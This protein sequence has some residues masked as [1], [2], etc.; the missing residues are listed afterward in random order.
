MN[1]GLTGKIENIQESSYTWLANELK[2]PE[3]S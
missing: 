2:F 3:S 1:P